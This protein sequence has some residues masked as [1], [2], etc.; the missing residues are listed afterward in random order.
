MK[1]MLLLII[2]ILLSS[3][4]HKDLYFGDHQHLVDVIIHWPDEATPSPKGMRIEFFDK[5]PE[6]PFIGTEDFA[7][8]YGG[9]IDMLPDAMYDA[10]C[11][12]YLGSEINKIRRNRD[13]RGIQ[14]YT[15]EYSRASYTRANP[16]ERTIAM[17]DNFYMCKVENNR[18]AE[19]WRI[20]FY[21]TNKAETYTFEIRKVRGARFIT[22]L[23]GACSGVSGSYSLSQEQIVGD[24]STVLFGAGTDNDTERIVGSF[25]T[26]GHC[27]DASVRN[28]FTMELRY[29]SGNPNNGYR[30]QTWDVTDQM[31]N[32]THYIIID[33][34]I[35]IIPTG[36][37][38]SGF[39]VEVR[40]WDEL[41]IPLEL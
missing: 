18:V 25:R 26:F 11:Y 21:L 10:I 19:P 41:W 1:R 22:S 28:Y 5:T 24:W 14:V 6:S 34:D 20:D 16:D 9:Q 37:N 13:Y 2:T 8:P 15:N 36:R 12:D 33:W 4:Q 23:A 17:P 30:M 31:H 38:S 40:P 39:D 35:Q 27:D 32:G 3:C 7:S 29:P